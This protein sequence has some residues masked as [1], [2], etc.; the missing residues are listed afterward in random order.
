MLP[1]HYHC[2]ILIPCLF[3]CS[4]DEIN[5]LVLSEYHLFGPTTEGLRGNRYGNDNEV[6]TAVLNWL[7]HQPAELYNT[8]IHALVQWFSTFFLSWPI[9]C[10]TKV[11]WPINFLSF[12]NEH[13]SPGADPESFDGGD[14]ILN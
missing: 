9:F 8:G 11:L 2:S 6:K 3:N 5:Q 4:Q 12:L 1:G 14:V 10:C 13:S 7:R